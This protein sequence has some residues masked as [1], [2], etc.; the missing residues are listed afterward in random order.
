[1]GHRLFIVFDRIEQFLYSSLLTS[2]FVFLPWIIHCKHIGTDVGVASK[3][4][5]EYTLFENSCPICI[6]SLMLLCYL[7]LYQSVNRIT[8]LRSRG[9]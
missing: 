9:E 3:V 7:Q 5:N 6:Y 8:A 2:L 1:M 4:N